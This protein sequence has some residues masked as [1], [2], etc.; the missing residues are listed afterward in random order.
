M[1]I[2]VVAITA[3]IIIISWR[4]RDINQQTG[5]K[6]EGTK[7]GYGMQN[8]GEKNNNKDAEEDIEYEETR[9]LLQNKNMG[10]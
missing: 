1:M 4:L 9:T 3:F 8:Q 7:K 5:Q 10:D 6:E 2:T